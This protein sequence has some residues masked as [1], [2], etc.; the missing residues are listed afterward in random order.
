M[1]NL[2][3]YVLALVLS[4]P[5]AFIVA[6]LTKDEKP[7]YKKYFPY[8]LVVIGV[9]ALVFYFLNNLVEAL[10]LTFMFLVVLI[11]RFM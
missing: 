5:L 2:I 9:L 6:S 8:F 4:F 1:Q 7:I 10:T 11:W 3:L